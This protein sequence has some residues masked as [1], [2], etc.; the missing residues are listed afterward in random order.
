MCYVRKIPSVKNLYTLSDIS[1]DILSNNL[2]VWYLGFVWC[3]VKQY[4]FLAL[5]VAILFQGPLCFKLNAYIFLGIFFFF[6]ISYYSINI[7]FS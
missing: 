6:R 4:T 7:L 1:L 2:S 3:E 5:Q